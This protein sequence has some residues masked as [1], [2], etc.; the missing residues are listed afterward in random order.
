MSFNENITVK[1]ATSA[2]FAGAVD[3]NLI[4]RNGNNTT[5]QKP[6]GTVTSQPR[7][8]ITHRDIGKNKVLHTLT[9]SMRPLVVVDGVDTYPETK[10]V[11]ARFNFELPK[12]YNSQE[13]EAIVQC[14]TG[15]LSFVL[16]DNAGFTY[17]LANLDAV[18]SILG[19]SSGE[20][21]ARIVAGES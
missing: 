21:L 11:N 5:R 15:L 2:T 12:E 10:R 16:A 7:M 3:L 9:M 13:Y 6:G 18:H 20:M 19:K 8:T 14:F 1:P 4:S 17:P